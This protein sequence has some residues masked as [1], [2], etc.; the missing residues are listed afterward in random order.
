MGGKG[1]RAIENKSIMSR[2]ITVL[3][4]IATVKE[5]EGKMTHM[6]EPERERESERESERAHKR[7]REIGKY[8]E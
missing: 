4:K 8:R 3:S 7:S 2:M 6:R 1:T 5:V